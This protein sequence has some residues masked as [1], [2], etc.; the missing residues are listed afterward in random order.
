MDRITTVNPVRILWCCEDRGVSIVQMAKDVGIAES[1]I[2]K[3][4]EEGD[5]LTYSQLLK[6]SN[7]FGRGVLFFL[8]PSPVDAEQVHTPQFR[9]LAN[10]KP[11]MSP[12]VKAII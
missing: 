9:T 1:T 3:L 7:Y 10:Q 6:L 5:G 8:D 2:L 4:F 12:K 11:E